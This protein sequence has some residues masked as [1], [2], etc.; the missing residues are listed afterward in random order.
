MATYG[1]EI[2]KI[3]NNPDQNY[4]FQASLDALG[5]TMVVGDQILPD[6]EHNGIPR[7]AP[8]SVKVYKLKYDSMRE[9]QIRLD[10]TRLS[11]LDQKESKMSCT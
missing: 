10:A 6:F 3:I 8:G 11:E 7:S 2:H 4:G 1:Y 9:K 5:E